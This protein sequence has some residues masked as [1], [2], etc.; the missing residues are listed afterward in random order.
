MMEPIPEETSNEFLSNSLCHQAS[1]DLSIQSEGEYTLHADYNTQ[2]YDE[3]INES[4]A[5][6]GE[7]EIVVEEID[8][9]DDQSSIIDL[10]PGD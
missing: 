2:E 4:F 5:Q 8:S 1:P 7:T 9:I 6:N 3:H 10:G